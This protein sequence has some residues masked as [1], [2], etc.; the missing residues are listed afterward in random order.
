MRPRSRAGIDEPGPATMKCSICGGLVTWR[1][2]LANLTHTQCESCGGIN[3]QGPENFY[4]DEEEYPIMNMNNNPTVDELTAMFSACNDNDGHHVL[5]VSKNG[6]VTLSLL[7][8]DQGPNQFEEAT[9]DMQ[10]R[11]ETFDCGN[12]YVG[13]E[14][15]SDSRFMQRIFESLVENWPSLRNKNYVEYI[16]I[17]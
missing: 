12:G 6:D 4:T 1:G 17:Y 14:A 9:L 11:Y 8:K 13:K 2:P 16:D 3:C 5:W 7:S 15:A 10:F